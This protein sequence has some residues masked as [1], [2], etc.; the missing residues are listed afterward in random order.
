MV[1]YGTDIHGKGVINM[2]KR[3]LKKKFKNLYYEY[4]CLAQIFVGDRC[5]LP[6]NGYP[7]W[8]INNAHESAYEAIIALIS[9]N[10]AKSAISLLGIRLDDPSSY[11]RKINKVR[12]KIGKFNPPHVTSSDRAM[13]IIRFKSLFK[14]AVETEMRKLNRNRRKYDVEYIAK[15]MAFGADID[16][17]IPALAPVVNTGSLEDWVAKN[18]TLKQTIFSEFL[19]EHIKSQSDYIEEFGYEPLSIIPGDLVDIPGEREESK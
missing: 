1:Y 16:G 7:L 3:I 19:S 5:K 9:S 15:C 4:E 18:T 12:R 17:D 2:N 6:L 10:M 14:E 13:M 11:H 8:A